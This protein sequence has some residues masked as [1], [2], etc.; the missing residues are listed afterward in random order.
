M[1][2]DS[3]PEAPPGAPKRK[4]KVK[5]RHTVGRVILV[6]A[7]VLALV[8]GL[9]TVY[10]IRHLDGNIEGISTDNLGDRP[11]EVY[12][13]NGQPLDILVMG[14]DSRD[15]EGCGIDTEGGGGSDVGG[16]CFSTDAGSVSLRCLAVPY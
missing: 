9:G 8:T 12:T 2:D 6:S 3:S 10:F 13:G 7:L 15:C 1:S 16:G 5:R 14:S 4:G 11:E